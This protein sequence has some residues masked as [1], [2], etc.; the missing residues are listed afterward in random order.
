MNYRI[1][2]RVKRIERR[3]RSIGTY[4]EGEGESV[5]THSVTEDIG[6]FVQFEGLWEAIFLGFDEPLLRVGQE[7]DLVVE[8]RDK[9]T[10]AGEHKPLLLLT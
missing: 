8:P 7:V 2:T 4:K 5:T 6:W 9:N 3:Q 10:L 1:Q